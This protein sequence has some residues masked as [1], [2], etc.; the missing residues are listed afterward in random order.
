MPFSFIKQ[1][2]L[3]YI[4]VGEINHVIDECGSHE[5]VK[6]AAV[7]LAFGTMLG[8][9]CGNSRSYCIVMAISIRLLP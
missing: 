3:L 1:V 4:I 8:K 5:I 7:S 2:Y 9:V 6:D